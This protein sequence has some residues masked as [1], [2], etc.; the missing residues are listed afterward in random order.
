[1][2]ALIELYDH[3]EVL[4]TCCEY[5]EDVDIK[6]LI[7]TRPLIKDDLEKAG[8]N[9]KRVE[10]LLLGEGISIRGLLEKHESRLSRCEYIFLLTANRPFSQFTKLSFL[11]KTI[12]LVHNVHAFLTPSKHLYWKWPNWT[13]ILLRHLRFL[14]SGDRWHLSMLLKAVHSWAFPTNF[15]RQNAWNNGWVPSGQSSMVLPLD[16]YKPIP[17]L[18]EKDSIHI[19][20][21]GTIKS[22]GRN[23]NMVIRAFE[24]FLAHSKQEIHL[25]LLG[26]PKGSYGIVT[27]EAFKHLSER[28]HHFTLQ[29]Y[30]DQIPQ[31]IYDAQLSKADFLILPLAKYARYNAYCER[32]GY[33]TISGGINDMIRFGLPAL[34]YYTY[35]IEEKE[36]TLVEYYTDVSSLSSRL[37]NWVKNKH[38]EEKVDT[39]RKLANQDFVHQR[40]SLF[41]A[42]GLNL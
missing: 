35:P 39:Y 26:R 12:L 18:R 23:Y 33:S 15:I 8:L 25:V 29:C 1:M 38:Y 14:L 2:I 37:E 40:T 30:D 13:N 27:Q 22:N 4:R 6:L 32:I 17:K 41:Q 16:Y 10:W 11:P 9:S 31:D 5:W 3:S 34:L 21:P 24:Q 19:C 42:L 36:R 28:Y 20:I 7:I